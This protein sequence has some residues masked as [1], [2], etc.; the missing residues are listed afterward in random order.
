[1]PDVPVEL[2]VVRHG[3]TEWSRSGQHTSTTDLPL[4][5]GGEAA[6]RSLGPRLADVE[7]RFG[8]V[9]TSPLQRCVRT[10]ALAGFPDAERDPDLVEWRYGDYEGLTTPE[11]R[12]QV[13][14]WT[15]WTHDTPGGETATAVG[16]RI[17]RVLQR[18][19]DKGV[20][21]ALVFAHAHAGRVLVARWLELGP[22]DGR[23]FRLGTATISVLGWDHEQPALERLNC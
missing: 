10:A 21:R 5:S 7:P 17:D 22:A 2:W 23:R 9:L 19:R 1:M 12:E 15:V 4:T 20:E 6:A 13:P 8:V 18:I 11:I 16:A 3:E 14:G